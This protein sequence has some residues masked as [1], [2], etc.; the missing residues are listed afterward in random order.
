[1][2]GFTLA[3]L[4]FMEQSE[5]YQFVIY[6]SIF[7]RFYFVF[8]ASLWITI[9]SVCLLCWKKGT[10]FHLSCYF[11]VNSRGEAE[12]SEANFKEI[13]IWKYILLWF[14]RLNQLIN[15]FHCINNR[16]MS[17]KACEERLFIDVFAVQR[18]RT[19]ENV[20]VEGQLRQASF[21]ELIS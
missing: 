8:L 1:M 7:F 17:D 10:L 19:C 13:Y 3:K 21:P 20:I 6:V 18:H 14:G 15:C 16:N 2:P 4:L 12:L 11:W 5:S 9:M